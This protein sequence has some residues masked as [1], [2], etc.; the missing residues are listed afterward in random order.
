MTCN[1]AGF[2]KI[3]SSMVPTLVILAVVLRRKD[4]LD[5]HL[6]ECHVHTFFRFN[7]PRLALEESISMRVC[8]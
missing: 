2:A 7:W 1:V 6:V 4:V 3:R 5:F 8:I